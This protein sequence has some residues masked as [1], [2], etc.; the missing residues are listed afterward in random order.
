VRSQACTIIDPVYGPPLGA[1]ETEYSATKL[2]VGHEDCLVL[3]TDGVTEAR[4]NGELFGERRLLDTIGDRRGCS[5]QELADAVLAACQSYAGRLQDD[6]QV[7][8]LRLV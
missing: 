3:Y 2:T 7:M 4:R 1:F 8:A 6:L 5:A